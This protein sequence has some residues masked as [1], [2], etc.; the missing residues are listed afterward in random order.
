MA[1]GIALGELTARFLEF[2]GLDG[3]EMSFQPFRGKQNR[4]AKRSTVVVEAEKVSSQR[5]L[6]GGRTVADLITRFHAL[7]KE[8]EKWTEAGPN[9]YKV[10]ILDH[11][12]R[13]VEEQDTMGSLRSRQN[14]LKEKDLEKARRTLHSTLKDFE[15]KLEASDIV[16]LVREVLKERYSG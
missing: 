5:F 12:G 9:C 7:A 16:P 13:Q 15:R 8:T 3:F 4:R 6:Q 10:R 11:Q 1:K 14:D 2:Q